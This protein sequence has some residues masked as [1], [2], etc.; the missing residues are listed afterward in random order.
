MTDIL[1]VTGPL[2]FV[3]RNLVN[4]LKELFN[5]LFNLNALSK[6]MDVCYDENNSS[7]GVQTMAIKVIYF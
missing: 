3:G 1:L 7:W 2:G 4:F 6:A 5:R